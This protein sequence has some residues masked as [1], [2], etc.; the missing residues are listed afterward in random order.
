MNQVD[1]T[2]K[3]KFE[4]LKTSNIRV[5]VESGSNTGSGLDKFDPNALIN[6]ALELDVAKEINEEAGTDVPKKDNQN[7][8]NKGRKK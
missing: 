1:Q 4:A 6:K 5:Y 8:K 3:A 7:N 2:T